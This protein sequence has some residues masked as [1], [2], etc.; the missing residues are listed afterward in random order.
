MTNVVLHAGK[1][2]ERHATSSDATTHTREKQNGLEDN[3]GNIPSPCV[4]DGRVSDQV[5]SRHSPLERM[6]VA[7]L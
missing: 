6:N 1:T 5:L 7:M 4:M 2:E 3:R